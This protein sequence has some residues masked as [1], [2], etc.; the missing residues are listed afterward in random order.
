MFPVLVNVTEETPVNVL[1]FPVH[2]KVAAELVVKV[3]VSPVNVSVPPVK[4]SDDPKARLVPNPVNVPPAIEKVPLVVVSVV[5]ALCVIVLVYVDAMVTL[6]TV[7]LALIVLRQL[8]PTHVLSNVRSSA[9]TGEPD[10]LQLPAVLQFWSTPDAPVH[11]R[12]VPN[13]C[14]TATIAIIPSRSI[15]MVQFA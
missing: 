11:V 4:L 13:A 9:E 14:P 8:A 2:V 15:C 1:K 5:P 10:G 7:I 3:R 6:R 12:A